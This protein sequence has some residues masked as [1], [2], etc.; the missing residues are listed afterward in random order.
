[1]VWLKLTV[2]IVLIVF[3]GRLVAGYADVIA[4]RTGLGRLWVGLILTSLVTSLP[5]VFN[6][7][8]AVTIVHA[9]DLTIGNVLG[10]NTFNLANL[11]FLDIIGR[12]G[13]ILYGSSKN[14]R[15]TA[16]FS[17]LI[18]TVAA[19]GI[20]TSQHFSLPALGWVGWY[21]PVI[22]IVYLL[23]AR[24]IFVAEKRQLHELKQVEAEI[25]PEHKSGKSVYLY[26][27]LSSLVIIGAGIWLAII[28]EEVAL[29]TGWDRSFV[30]SM[31]LAFSTTMPE[32]TVSLTAIRIGAEDLAIAN[33]IGSNLF[34]ITI[35]TIGEL[36]YSK[37]PILSDVSPHHLITAIT[38]IALNLLLM[39]GLRNPPQREFHRLNWWNT[40]MLILF[41][42]SA[43]YRF[44]LA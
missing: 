5:E 6:A 29:M 24:T 1:M 18:V 7:V 26:F 35:I 16:R 14:H 17:L 13:C 34:N 20:Y 12:S 44:T 2:C 33:M 31:F 23:S 43:F 42:V 41:L 3:T 9:P 25:E 32:I 37:G 22:L 15:I 11:A 21:T 10:A 27:I 4:R 19:L 38:V 8:S 36:L 39:A 30:G 28:G 40:S